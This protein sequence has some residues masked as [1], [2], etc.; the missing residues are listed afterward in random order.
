MNLA[1]N[2]SLDEAIAIISKA[3]AVVSNDSGLMN[4]ASALNRPIVVMYGPTDMH[5]TPPFS[6]VAQAV[7]LHLACAPCHQRECPLGHH[8]CMNQ[9]SADL[10]WQ[11]LR[12]M[13]QA[14]TP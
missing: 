5:N 8:N 3:H 14:E 1:V 6:E 13:M 4:I 10:V 11:P 12:A 9:L 2:T 7:S